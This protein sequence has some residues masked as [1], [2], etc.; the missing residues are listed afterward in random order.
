[1]T[2]EPY[3]PDPV[4]QVD[5]SPLQFN[6][7]GCATTATCL[8]R[9]TRGRHTTTGARMRE[10]THD[11]V[12]GTTLDQNDRAARE[13]WP[14]D[15]H[16]D[17]RYMLPFE[18]AVELIAEGRGA[19]VQGGYR[20]FAGTSLDGSPGFTGNHSCYWN[21]VRIVRHPDGGID[22][23]RSE[24]QWYD[25]LWNARRLGIP[26]REFRW[27]ALWKVADF[28]AHLT[29]ADGSHVGA[30]YCYIGFTRDTEPD[31]EKPVVVPIDYGENRMIVA[32]GLTL[33]SSHVMSLGQGQKLYREPKVGSP[34][35][36]RMAAD[37]K[38]G[39]FGN[40]APG[41]RAVLVR[42][43]NFP[44]GARRPVQVFVP[45]SAGTVSAR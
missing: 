43:A 12:G 34:V 8:D 17:V 9:D 2:T 39:Y 30:G 32:G 37:G 28:C 21:A 38:V 7:C 35:V 4:T 26:S 45:A 20:T 6:N 18:D 40:A 16:M 5:G 22:Y 44:D 1:M 42:T 36:T 13:G 29:F 19:H 33:T 31:A 27:I 10:L 15:D 14:P 24:A 41:W 25:P 3:Q 11:T 23:L